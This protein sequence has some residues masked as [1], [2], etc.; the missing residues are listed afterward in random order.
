MNRTARIAGLLYLIVVATGMFNLGYVSSHVLLQGDPSAVMQRV[1]QRETL[2]R[3][4]VIAD[5][6]CNAT[7]LILPLA[8][9]R[10]LGA[11]HRNAALL[12]VALA[13]V[14][15]PIAF[16]NATH[17]LDL[18]WL[19]GNAARPGTLNT[20]QLHAQVMLALHAYR[21]G[22]LVLEV[23]WG[24]WLAPLGYLV[25]KCGFLPRLLG[26]LLMLGCVGYLFDFLGTLLVP[27][28]PASSLA[29]YINLP[30]AAGEMGTCL[31]LLVMGARAPAWLIRATAR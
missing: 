27:A 15:V 11:T 4:G 5:L 19:L 17:R 23:F 25:F 28:Y 21:N 30:A 12:M 3:F 20:E 1:L 8:L 14:Q 2:L 18:L 13:V 22:L 26:A 29:D 31:W 16:V 24:L 9:Y 7:F 10:L 6:V